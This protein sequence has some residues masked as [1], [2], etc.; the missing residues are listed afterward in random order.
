[1]KRNPVIGQTGSV[2]LSDASI[3]RARSQIRTARYSLIVLSYPSGRKHYLAS[4][5]GPFHSR[6]YG[7]TGFG[8]DKKAAKA[9]LQRRLAND[10]RYFGSLRLSAHDTS[11]SVGIVNPRL[12]DDQPCTD[13]EQDALVRVALGISN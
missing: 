9:A 5:N 11:D 10:Y 7:A 4:V 6:T 1:M 3:Q 8:T 12:L 13:K 2:D